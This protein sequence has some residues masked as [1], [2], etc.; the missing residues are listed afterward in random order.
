MNSDNSGNMLKKLRKIQ[1]KQI[2][3][4][5]RLKASTAENARRAASTSISLN[6]FHAECKLPLI[7]GWLSTFISKNKIYS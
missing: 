4:L 3:Y 2:Q 5:G 6:D 1:S 7:K